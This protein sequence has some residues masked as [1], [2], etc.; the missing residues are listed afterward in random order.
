MHDLPWPRGVAPRL[1]AHWRLKLGWIPAFMAAFFGCYFLVLRHP[2][3]PVTTLPATALDGWIG[4]HPGA[5]GLYVSLW[6]YVLVPVSL[7][8]RRADLAVFALGAGALAAAG[9]LVFLAWPTAVPDWN[10]D[11]ARYG[12][13]ARLK[14][15]D[16]TGNAC[17]SLHAAFAVYAA[18]WIGRILRRLRAPL[19]ARLVNFA[20]CA[21]IL[22]A[23]IATRQHVAIDLYA[24]AALGGIVARL[25]RIPRV[26]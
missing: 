14:S 7:L 13:I 10:L 16:A 26:S 20:W 12:A 11:W 4:F 18:A 25:V 22:Y 2:L 19:P 24:G 9:L 23:T 6:I 3:L 21:G 8:D 5:L 17:P 1:A 15:A